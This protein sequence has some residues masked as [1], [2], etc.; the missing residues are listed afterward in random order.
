[1]REGGGA[2][3]VASMHRSRAFGFIAPSILGLSLVASLG[4]RRTT[5]PDGEQPKD[6]T[7]SAAAELALPDPLPLPA[8]PRLGTW[9]A[10]PRR[11]VA[12]IQPYS[13]A[14]IE[15]G[16]LAQQALQGLTTAELAEQIA[17]GIN[18][19][20]PFSNVVLDDGQ[21]VLRMGLTPD[22]RAA[23]GQ[24]FAALEPAG[25][26][27]GVRLPSIAREGSDS[28]EWL[29][30]I[31][32]AEGGYLVLAN[33]E[34]GLATGRALEDTYGAQPVFF[35]IE[36]SA[37][38]ISTDELPVARALGKGSL[39]ALTIEVETP[40]G[41]DPLAK[42]PIG[43]G[44]LAGLL[45]APDI[46]AGASSTY[47]DYDAVV[48]ELS[49]QA[50]A[51]VRELPFLIR[52]IGE[53]IAASFNTLLRTW[54]GRALV[55]MGPAK[56][57]RVAYGANDVKKSRVAMIRLLQKVTDNASVARNF[58]NMVPKMYLRRRVATGDGVDIEMFVLGDAAK[59]V[60]AEARALVDGEGRLNIA[61][62][63]SERAGGGMMVIGPRADRELASWLDASADAPAHGET[64]DQLFAGV[65]AADPAKL[66]SLLVPG[67][68]P[69][70][71]QLL[72]LAANGPRWG[73]TVT[74]AGPERY[75]IEVTT[76]GAP[77]PP[78][79]K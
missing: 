47:T 59:F 55:A 77:R 31:D 25:D 63:W 11:A 72:N 27:G 49:S 22:A 38:S 74:A 2:A 4:C 10:Q 79:A 12:M 75:T 73:V 68:Q 58:T 44:T 69:D 9:L 56:H 8:E 43:P 45:A 42:L 1:M 5:T 46:V 41:A 65:F 78:R 30:W 70:V 20:Q 67:Q 26:F 60:P 14:P 54:D 32:E 62:A 53:D 61:M 71:D 28:R 34:A 39:D 7:E 40:P 18:L 64:Q 6:Q 66:Q 29:A 17:A 51:M 50:N 48:S 21:E 35:S 13:P 52:S 76:P 19:E 24:R 3:T 33:S 16:P 23:L 15:I 37:L 36:P 57:L